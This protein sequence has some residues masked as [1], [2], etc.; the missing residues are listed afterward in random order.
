MKLGEAPH[1]GGPPKLIL[2]GKHLRSFEG[3]DGI[4]LKE[5][6]AID[7]WG[8]LVETYWIL[9]QAL[10]WMMLDFR[11]F[12]LILTSHICI[13]IYIYNYLYTYMPTNSLFNIKNTSYLDI[14]YTYIHIYLHTCLSLSLFLHIHVHIQNLYLHTHTHMYRYITSHPHTHSAVHM[15]DF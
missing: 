5:F 1:F 6:V 4:I 11:P 13:Y 10:A 15:V 14:L 9:P 7:F 8:S 2:Q 12:W 3:F